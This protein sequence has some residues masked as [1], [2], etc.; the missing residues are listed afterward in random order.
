MKKLLVGILLMVSVSASAV[1][2]PKSYYEKQLPYAQALRSVV[3]AM[4]SV[5][6]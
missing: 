3:N 2:P 4:W 1:V 6:F 5:I